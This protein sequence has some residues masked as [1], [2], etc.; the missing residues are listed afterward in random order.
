M[1][2]DEQFEGAG[3]EALAQEIADAHGK[4]LRDETI[5]QLNAARTNNAANKDPQAIADAIDPF[6]RYLEL[7]IRP[8]VWRSLRARMRATGLRWSAAKQWIRKTR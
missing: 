1:P 8:G 7:R 4:S 2:P 3:A 6:A 5:R